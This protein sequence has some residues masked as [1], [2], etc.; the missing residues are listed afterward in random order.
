MFS[1][2][3]W[4]I[5]FPLRCRF[6][7]SSRAC[8]ISSWIFILKREEISL[9][10]WILNRYYSW[11]GLSFFHL[12][13]EHSYL[14]PP[15][16]R[17]LIDPNEQKSTSPTHPTLLAFV[18]HD[19]SRLRSNLLVL[20]VSISQKPGEAGLVVQRLSLHVPLRWPGVRRFGSR[21]WTWHCLSSH[22]VVGVPHIK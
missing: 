4:N 8:V 18:E 1:F 13:L 20:L 21:A 12:D 10:Q 22:A 5:L 9:S 16:S 17:F 15:R 2:E 6:F 7:L 11:T 14:N 19:S 3:K